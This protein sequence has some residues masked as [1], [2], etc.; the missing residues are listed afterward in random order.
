MK[1]DE[2]DE[3]MRVFETAHDYYVV[4]GVFIVA[5]ID[6]RSFTKLTKERHQFEAP[7][8]ER[9]RDMMLATVEHL[10]SCGFRVA[11]GYTQSDEISLLIHR[12][13]DLF[14]RKM[15]KLNSVLAG[16]A[17]AKFSLLLGDIACFDCRIC[18]LP[19]E[20]LVVDYFR[21]RNED[22]ARNALNAHCYWMLR[23][24]GESDTDASNQLLGLSVANKNELLF[25]NGV[26]F[27][28]LP[29][30]QKR[31]VGIWW[32]EIQ[33]GGRNP[34][35]GEEVTV[36]RKRLSREFDLPI[37][38]GYDALVRERLKDAGAA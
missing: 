9:F 33:K 12:D 4:P 18:E 24:R 3:K 14:N 2:L 36:I 5:R 25:Q 16:E 6:G 13:E 37:R 38:D 17:S 32:R 34:K 21:W 15:R 22:A 35:T 10:M 7:F 23:K 19:T 28:D 26:N 30:W 11:Y 8:D 29:Q 1:F 27:N 20:A 31:G